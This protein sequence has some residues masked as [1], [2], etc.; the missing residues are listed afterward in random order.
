MNNSTAINEEYK[1][2][3]HERMKSL[4][5]GA[6]DTVGCRIIH[7]YVK[8]DDYI[9]Y[10]YE[11][12][13]G[14]ITMRVFID[15]EIEND[16]KHIGLNYDRI[17]PELNKFQ[18]VIDK[19]QDGRYAKSVAARALGLALNGS[20]EDA[21]KILGDLITKIN[22]EYID[23]IKCKMTYL[24]SCVSWLILIS[25]I[26]L[27]LYL[28]RD[29]GFWVKQTSILPIFFCFVFAGYGGFISVTRKMNNLIM[30]KDLKYANYIAYG[31]ERMI[32]ANIS[33]I[34]AFVLIKSGFVLSLI[35]DV[36]EPIYGL[37]AVS[38]LSGFSE[39]YVPDLLI[40]MET[41]K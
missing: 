20:I 5:V 32:I 2:K 26:G 6:K 33:G 40:K 7:I 14:N 38:I 8:T 31:I 30:E 11:D 16:P 34:V 18:S 9:M 17:K 29:R 23:V 37:I 4:V 3:Q 12:S 27:I 35:K 24:L 19:A 21:S 1:K 13:K 41:K 25:I 36:K 15:T 10:D 22:K 28:N 39:N